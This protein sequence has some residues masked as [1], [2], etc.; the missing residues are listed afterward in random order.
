MAQFERRLIQE[1][2]LAVL[3]AARARSRKGGRPSLS[4]NDPRIITA[5]KMYDNKSLS[6]DNIYQMLKV[7]RSAFYRFLRL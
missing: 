4:L 2:T 5:K 6:I 7:S 1:R 3:E